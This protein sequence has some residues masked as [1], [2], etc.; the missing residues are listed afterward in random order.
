MTLKRLQSLIVGSKTNKYILSKIPT[1][2]SF[3]LACSRDR[4]KTFEEQFGSCSW[5]QSYS[6]TW[7]RLLQRGNND[8]TENVGCGGG[9]GGGLAS[10]KSEHSCNNTNNNK[11]GRRR[12]VWSGAL[13]NRAHIT[14]LPTGATRFQTSSM[15][16]LKPKLRIF[17]APGG[18]TTSATAQSCFTACR[19][20]L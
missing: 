10:I 20:K 13:H 9:I 16:K 8:E 7:I 2:I 19:L 5:S 4:V 12:S 15:K 17:F 3:S 18:L 1:C 14:P 11:A 6:L